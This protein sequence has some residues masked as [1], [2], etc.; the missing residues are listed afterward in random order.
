MSLHSVKEVERVTRAQSV[1]RQRIGLLHLISCGQLPVTAYRVGDVMFIQYRNISVP[2]QSSISP[3]FIQSP[4]NPQL[5][6][7][8]RDNDRSVTEQGRGRGGPLC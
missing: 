7:R 1:Q 6:Q 5:R 4:K 3:A 8:W 2:C